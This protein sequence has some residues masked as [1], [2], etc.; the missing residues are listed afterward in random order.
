M[1]GRSS[2]F[3]KI[4][5]KFL[6][7]IQPLNSTSTQASPQP[8]RSDRTGDEAVSQEWEAQRRPAQGAA[9]TVDTSPIA[10]SNSFGVLTDIP[11]TPIYIRNLNFTF[12]STPQSQ[13]QKRHKQPG[14][15]IRRRLDPS[16]RSDSDSME[17]GETATVVSPARSGELDGFHSLPTADPDVVVGDT[18]MLASQGT[19][20]E[21]S[22]RG[23]SLLNSSSEGSSSGTSMEAGGLVLAPTMPGSPPLRG[24][25]PLVLSPLNM[26]YKGENLYPTDG[27]VIPVN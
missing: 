25:T 9:G 23:E 7:K 22:L 13:K 12:T 10:V 20:G 16:G 3:S 17:A 4:K 26:S 8:G 27:C 21:V 2:I 11:S 18:Q 19:A 1:Q 24:R 6:T 5:L 15:K 14:T